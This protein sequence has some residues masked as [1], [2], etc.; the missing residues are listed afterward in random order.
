VRQ[1]GLL[2]LAPEN[3]V[4]QDLVAPF[5]G[6]RDHLREQVREQLSDVF[7]DQ[8]VLRDGFLVLVCHDRVDKMNC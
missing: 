4:H 1:V 8:T 3:L 6:K 2:E 7:D 5:R